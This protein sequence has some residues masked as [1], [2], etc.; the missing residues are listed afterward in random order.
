MTMKKTATQALS[1]ALPVMAG[2]VAIGIPCGILESQIGMDALMA[3]VMSATF[4]SG[5]GQFMECNMWLAGLP[6]SSIIAS[7]SFVNTRQMLYS[8]AFSPYFTNV[9]KRLTFLFSATVTDESFGVNLSHF[10]SDETWT[11]THATLVNLFCMTSWAV[12]A[13]VGALV[14]SAVAIPTAIAA[15]AMTSI[16]ICLLVS[17]PLNHITAVVMVVA[18]AGVIVCKLM[19]LTAP[20]ILIGACAGVVAGMVAREVRVG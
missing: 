19:G 14:G 8:A 17:Q 20:A 15:F 12:S 4:Y 6:M 2:Y 3:F 5:A 18:A 7:V 16:F 13:A 10:V 11:A 9:R 1:A